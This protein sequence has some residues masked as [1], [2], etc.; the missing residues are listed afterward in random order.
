MSLEL[1]YSFRISYAINPSRECYDFLK[2]KKRFNMNYILHVIMSQLT[3]RTGAQL[4][5]RWT[6]NK[7]DSQQEYAKEVEEIVSTICDLLLL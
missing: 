3:V 1:L 6:D 4:F 5:L 2:L 7:I